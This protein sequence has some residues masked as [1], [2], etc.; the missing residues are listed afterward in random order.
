[1]STDE[2]RSTTSAHEHDVRQELSENP[3]LKVLVSLRR[4]VVLVGVVSLIALLN[5]GRWLLEGAYLLA[6]CLTV[7]YVLQ[8]ACD[9]T[10]K[11]RFNGAALLLFLM[12]AF[13]LAV[14]SPVLLSANAATT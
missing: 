7:W 9:Y 10:G 4:I 1:M 2:Q 5:A 3:S 11:R 12:L 13:A 8:V 14:I 6:A